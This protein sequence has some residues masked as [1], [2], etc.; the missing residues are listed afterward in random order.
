MDSRPSSGR[1]GPVFHHGVKLSYKKDNLEVFGTY[2]LPPH[3][4]DNSTLLVSCGNHRA[5]ICNDCPQ[6]YG[7]VWC[8]G[9]CSWCESSQKCHSLEE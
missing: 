5:A 6:G 9:E 7:E 1:A 2:G 3:D 4:I 8:N